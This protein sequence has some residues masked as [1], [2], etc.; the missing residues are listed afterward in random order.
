MAYSTQADIELHFLTS[1]LITLTDDE[2][3]GEVSTARVAAAITAADDLID[4]YLRGRYDVPLT[5]PVPGL[6]NRCSVDLAI[7]NLYNR[8]R[9]LKVPEDLDKT[10]ERCIALLKD[11]Q[12]G[13]VL[14]DVALS[15]SAPD[16][17]NVLCNKDDDDRVFNSDTL[18][19]MP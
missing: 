15:T 1:E 19:T 12:R 10:Y 13:T 3:I 6:V 18:D 5:A 4:G 11:I 7:Y 9:F 14:L 8:K 2:E 16:E 17:L